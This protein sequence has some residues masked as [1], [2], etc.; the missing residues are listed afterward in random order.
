MLINSSIISWIRKCQVTE[1]LQ[2]LMMCAPMCAQGDKAVLE[3]QAGLGDTLHSTEKADT[4]GSQVGG[5]SG[6]ES[7]IPI[8]RR[9]RIN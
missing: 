7:D 6:L 3:E 2:F 5:Q 4:G 8:L 1:C 9:N